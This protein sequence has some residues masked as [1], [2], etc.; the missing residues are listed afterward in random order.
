MHKNMT[1]MLLHTGRYRMTGKRLSKDAARATR[2][3]ANFSRRQV[4][5]TVSIVMSFALSL[6]FQ[7]VVVTLGQVTAVTVVNTPSHFADYRILLTEILR[8]LVTRTH[9]SSTCSSTYTH[10]RACT[11]T[12]THT[13]KSFLEDGSLHVLSRLTTNVCYHTCNQLPP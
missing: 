4:T 6:S 10:A 1:E 3:K 8:L 7:R 12:H 9:L 2:R 13:H 5:R 11:L